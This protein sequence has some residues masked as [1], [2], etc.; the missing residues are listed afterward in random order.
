M[1]RA[2]NPKLPEPLQSRRAISAADDQKVRRL[3]AR[4][5]AE[6]IPRSSIRGTIGSRP[7]HSQPSSDIP[8]RRSSDRTPTPSKTTVLGP[9]KSD[10]HTRK[11][12]LSMQAYR[13]ESR[14]YFSSKKLLP[15]GSVVFFS[16]KIRRYVH[17]TDGTLLDPHPRLQVL[18]DAESQELEAHWQT[19]LA[20]Y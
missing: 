5:F 19:A 12:T 6:L 15:V 7:F 11:E 17:P 3:G 13:T 1:S 4:I 8:Q 20:R 14:Y 18:S 2:I 9:R 10:A 16:N